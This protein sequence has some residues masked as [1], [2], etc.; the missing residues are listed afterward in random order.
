M[1]QVKSQV[2][3]FLLE[4]LLFFFFFINWKKKAKKMN[5]KI[6]NSIAYLTQWSQ[7]NLVAPKHTS[8]HV[9]AL[10]YRG[11]LLVHNGKLIAQTNT[12]ECC[13]ERSLLRLF[14]RPSYVKQY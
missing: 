14:E 8:F 6:Q 12:P 4:N 10:L 11:S 7:A 9:A 5:C 13:A 3:I 2:I 1:V